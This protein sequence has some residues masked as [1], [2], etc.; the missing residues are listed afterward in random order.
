MMDF[1]ELPIADWFVNTGYRLAR[2]PL[3]FDIESGF[4]VWCG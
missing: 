2:I 1:R 4:I 3:D